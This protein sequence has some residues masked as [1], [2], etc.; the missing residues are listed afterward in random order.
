MKA[1]LT[2]LCGCH[3]EIEIPDNDLRRIWSV[4]IRYR[5]AW[6]EPFPGPSTTYEVRKFE[7][8]SISNY[9]AAYYE[10]VKS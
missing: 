5:T 10:E 7:L 4:P 2:T 6:K 8:V 1:Y 3:K 9:P